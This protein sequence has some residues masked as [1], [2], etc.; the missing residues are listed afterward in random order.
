TSE[1]GSDIVL[2]CIGT[3]GRQLWKR[4][5]GT[6]KARFRSDEGNQASAS[7]C[8]NGKHVYAFTGT[9]DFACFDFAGTE[10]WRFNAQERYGKFRIQHGMHTTPLL[11]GDRLYLSL[12]HA[13]GMWV[14]GLEA[15]TG[16]EVWKVA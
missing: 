10:I 13:G 11:H 9:G 2:L 7:P 3:D 15:A 6:G 8:T 14:I 5:L 4:Q 12:L 16:Q 1:D